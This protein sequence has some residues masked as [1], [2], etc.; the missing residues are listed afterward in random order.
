M[1][2]TARKSDAGEWLLAREFAE[3]AGVTVR[4]LHHYDHCGL[5]KPKRRSGT[6]YRLYH[7][8]DLE[9]LEQVVALKFLG[10]PLGE[11][12][13][14]IE[15]KPSSLGQA[16]ARQRAGL[17]EKRRLL[18]KALVAIGDAESA[19]ANGK[20]AAEMLRRIIEAIEM[21]N[22]SNWM[23]KYY[24][25]SAQAKIAERAKGFTAEMQVVISR[26]WKEYYRDLNALEKDGDPDGSKARELELRHQELIAA[27]T[28]NDPEIEAG[29]RAL[30]EDHANWPAEMR[31][32]MK[33]F[34]HG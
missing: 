30:Y 12:R 22:D 16:L 14:V 33:E 21:Q 25:S 4:T 6:G 24:S 17:L 15:S 3:L 29:L 11:I 31:D 1:G 8:N 9:R 23:M 10:L 7:V 34:A 19:M 2:Q 20:P 32:R 27:F 5:L 28:G 13:R 18:D 26:A